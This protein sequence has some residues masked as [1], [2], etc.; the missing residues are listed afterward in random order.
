MSGVTHRSTSETIVKSRRS[1]KVCIWKARI[2][3]C[4][5]PG[6]VWSSNE[7]Y[8]NEDY[9]NNKARATKNVFWWYKRI[10]CIAAIC[11]KR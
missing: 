4:A 11:G 1:L 9:T 10:S 7:D 3:V 6:S 5:M 8:T 2:A